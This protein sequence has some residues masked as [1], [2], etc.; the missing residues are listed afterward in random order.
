MKLLKIVLALSLCLLLSAARQHLRSNI[1]HEISA[2]DAMDLYSGDYFSLLPDSIEDQVRQ[3]FGKE[4][5]STSQKFMDGLF[6]DD[7][8]DKKKDKDSSTFGRFAS[9]FG[10][11]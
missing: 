8:E 11:S 4:K 10:N 5:K 9:M 3:V 2:S 7:K 1:D 6:G